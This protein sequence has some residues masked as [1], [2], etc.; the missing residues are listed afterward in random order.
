MQFQPL[1]KVFRRE[2]IENIPKNKDK[3]PV[4]CTFL[5]LAHALQRKWKRERES[6]LKE[7][8]YSSF[9][10]FGIF[11]IFSRRKPLFKGRNCIHSKN[12]VADFTSA[13]TYSLRLSK[14]TKSKILLVLA[15]DCLNFKKWNSRER[16]VAVWCFYA[17]KCSERLRVRISGGPKNYFSEKIH[18]RRKIN[19]QSRG[20]KAKRHTPM[21]YDDL[22]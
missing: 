2:K 4:S 1:N 16:W 14:S 15:I 3:L 9:L 6:E 22:H 21:E 10:F 8:R 5:F 17:E 11:S 12:H 19:D 20:I 7:D 13:K 18:Q